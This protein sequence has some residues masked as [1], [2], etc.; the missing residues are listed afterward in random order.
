MNRLLCQGCFSLTSRQGFDVAI[1]LSHLSTVTSDES[2]RTWGRS[3]ACHQEEFEEI[4][5]SF[6]K[7]GYSWGPS[8]VQTKERADCKERYGYCVSWEMRYKVGI[9]II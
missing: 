5:R 9:I 7:K 2:N 8:S 6:K 1:E 3:T 4:K